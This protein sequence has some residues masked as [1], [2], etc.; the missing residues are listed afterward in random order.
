[1][2]DGS[3]QAWEKVASQA[4]ADYY[5]FRARRDKSRSPRTGRVHDVVVLESPDWVNIVAVT[6]DERVLLVRQYR[7]GTEEIT[8]EIPGGMVDA[9]EP[10]ETAAKRELKEETGYEAER[11]HYLGQVK[12]NPAFM[13]NRCHTFLALDAVQ[14]G[15]P[16]FDGSEDIEVLTADLNQVS[17]MVQDGR[18]ANSLVVAAFYHLDHY[19]NVSITATG[20]SI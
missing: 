12:P 7:H 16:S 18:I 13:D 5:I 3:I 1:M 4:A 8:L 17:D 14:T 20:S 2:N 15:P 6:P 11:W 19:N 9:G 10:P